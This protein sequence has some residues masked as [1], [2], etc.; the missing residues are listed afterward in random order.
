M[1]N[2]YAIYTKYD[3]LFGLVPDEHKNKFKSGIMHD[4]LNLYLWEKENI[5]QIFDKKNNLIIKKSTF[6]TPCFNLYGEG[7]E[8]HNTFFSIL[9]EI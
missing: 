3:I 4:R 7:T 2:Y 5:I 1:T 6:L 8:L 9:E